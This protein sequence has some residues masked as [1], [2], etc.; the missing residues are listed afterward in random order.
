MCKKAVAALAP[1]HWRW[2]A[3]YK[4]R[5][6][7]TKNPMGCFYDGGANGGKNAFFNTDKVGGKDQAGDKPF[8]CNAHTI[9]RNSGT[10]A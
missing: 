5:D 6:Y 3:N 10:F 2:D 9:C 1:G 4:G 8:C 7:D